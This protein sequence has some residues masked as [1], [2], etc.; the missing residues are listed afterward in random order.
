MPGGLLNIISYGSENLILN[1]NPSKTFFKQIYKK[2]TNF[3]L[4]RFRIDFEGQRVLNF[5]SSSMFKFKIPRYAEL[6]WDT[7][8]VV[9]LPNIYSSFYLYDKEKQKYENYIDAPKNDEND[10]YSVDKNN[11][12][13][14]FIKKNNLNGNPGETYSLNEYRFKWIENLG[15]HMIKEIVIKSN[16][17]IIERYSGETMLFLNERDNTSKNELINN[18]IGNVNSLNDPGF[19]NIFFVKQSTENKLFN[20]NKKK[21]PNVIPI[22]NSSVE[23][24]IRGRKLYIP[25]MSWF[26]GKSQNAFP[27]IALQYSDLEIEIV[28]RPVNEL[29]TLY[30]KDK[31]I[32]QERT[33]KNFTVDIS[34]KYFGNSTMP[35]ITDIHNFLSPPDKYENRPK[36]NIWNSDIHLL[37]TYIFLSN[38]ERKLFAGQ[39]HEYLIKNIHEY[40]YK[41]AMG[42]ERI[43]IQSKDL[44]SGYMFRFRRSD[45]DIRN[46]WD[47]YSNWP[48]NKKSPIQLQIINA[49]ITEY[50]ENTSKL[51]HDENDEY[52]YM[53]TS[54]LTNN[55]IKNEYI[56][57][58]NNNILLTTGPL[59]VPSSNK[60]ILKKMGLL[61]NGTYREDLLES[62][63]Y[64]YVE[65]YSR[66]SGQAKHGLYIYNFSIYSNKDYYQPSGSQ[67]MNRTK[68][69]VFEFETEVSDLKI[70]SQA[71]LTTV[72]ELTNAQTEINNT[73]SAIRNNDTNRYENHK[74][75]YEL[76]LIEERYNILY[77]KNGVIE[78]KYAR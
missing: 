54:N 12:Q 7:Y 35:N 20:L 53:L 44:V 32:Y 56:L 37:S 59:L 24:S 39:N 26:S 15:F 55:H 62:G 38:E 52:K 14:T 50:D 40:N 70:D 75:D 76:F 10:Y 36:S 19:K 16:S 6:L 5:N 22:K 68:N 74:Y 47:N 61:F 51:N 34:P 69:V 3:G 18:M 1:G 48:Y 29:Y 63:I 8:I 73:I 17:K 57:D 21:Y 46:Q 49:Q 4:Q 64:N 65:K 72:E 30:D 13:I 2:Y 33:A 71:E 77:V 67:N 42:S 60:N 58:I 27:L 23:P 45:V 43:E 11:K 78:M 9:N 66:T 25:L 41:N 31:D 28:F